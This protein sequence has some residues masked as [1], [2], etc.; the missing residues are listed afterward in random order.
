MAT[1]NLGTLVTSPIRPLDDEILI[2]SVF[3]NE[4]KG[5]HHSYA[6]LAERD[7]IIQVRREWGMLCTV[8]NDPDSTKNGTYQLVY[9]ASNDNIMNPLN[10]V[11]FVGSKQ[12]VS[13]G[14][15]WLPSV[16]SIVDTQPTGMTNGDRFL[17]ATP[18]YGSPFSTQSNRIAEWSSAALVGTGDW[19]YTTPTNGT[20]IRV[21]NIPNS[22]YKF[23]G[24]WSEG[25]IWQREYLTQVRYIQPTSNDG[26]TYSFTSSMSLV[27]LDMYSYSVYYANFGMTNAGPS[28]LQIDGLGYYPIKKLNSGTLID[29]ASQEIVPNVQYHLSWNQGVFQVHNIGGG[30]GG[31]LSLTIGAAEDGTYSDGLFTDFNPSTPIGTPI[32]RFNEILLALVPPPAPDLSDWSLGGPQFVNGKLSFDSTVTSGLTFAPGFNRGSEFNASG[33][34]KGINSFVS[35]PKTTTTYF[36][37]YTGTLN[38]GTLKGPGDPTPAYPAN[39]F[40]NGITG[41]I[42]LRLNGATISNEPLGNKSAI[43]TTS[44]GFQSGLIISAATASKFPSGIPFEFFW[45]RTGSFLIKTNDPNL[46]QGF[47]YLDLSHILPTKTLTLASYSWVSDPSS[48]PTVFSSQNINTIVGSSPKYLSGVQFFTNVTLNY[49]LTMQNHVR[50]TYVATQVVTT[51][52]SVLGGNN[53]VI[54]KPT[55]T[56]LPIFSNPGTKF[57][58]PGSSPGNSLSSE[59]VT[60]NYS[61]S[62]PVRRLNEAVTF[63]TTVPRTVQGSDTGGTVSRDNFFIDNYPTNSSSDLIEEFVS[64]AYRV[65]NG[66]TKYDSVTDTYQGLPSWSSTE[67]LRSPGYDNG[68]Q[69]ING[70]LV[71]PS[72][73][74]SGV[75]GSDVNPNFGGGS[76]L[77]YFLCNTTVTGFGTANSGGTSNR[78]FTRL[79]RIDSQTN[80]GFLRFTFNCSDTTFVNATTP[81]T[82]NNCWCEVKI[83]RFTGA[84]TLPPGTNLIN[85]A[86]TGWLDL[87]K[88]AFPGSSNNGDGA[89]RGNPSFVNP[90]VIEVDLGPGR[91]TLYSSGYVLLRIT[92]PS[93][94]K[95]T[96]NSIVIKELTG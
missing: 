30:G 39:A 60:W 86:V 49:Q 36:A 53:P 77:N 90:T 70:Q 24:T 8:Y 50:N 3:S 65:R 17:I 62:S 46:R 56:S 95:G 85:G 34:R 68:L 84:P 33:Y 83:P 71:Y 4:A 88:K 78:T 81:L 92:A 40:G 94:W 21:D 93:S 18:S 54:N 82:F 10:W 22:I 91:G 5:G 14:G 57:I 87:T 37:D 61:L 55:E 43:N 79:F 76:N 32:D 72:F 48:I 38:F 19:I 73:T 64:E 52:N 35:Q 15:E 25:G 51:A 23:N 80:Y 96:I 11:L 16:L 9:N 75:G 20:T 1:V 13:V 67:S 6:T 89:H 29:L 74:F 7:A 26:G 63:T 44:G 66:S 69:V 59:V 31:T 28:T 45:H 12:T 47:N 41:S 58:F 42:V 27:P 2:S